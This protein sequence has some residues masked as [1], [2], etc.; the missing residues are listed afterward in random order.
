MIRESRFFLPPLF[1]GLLVLCLFVPR[2][3]GTE[4]Q[5]AEDA[6]RMLTLP[7]DVEKPAPP[8]SAKA[9][10]REPLLKGVVL[11]I[12]LREDGS[13]LAFASRSVGD[14]FNKTS[15]AKVYRG[16]DEI[17][18]LLRFAATLKGKKKISEEGVDL[19]VT[20][21]D[22]VL[23]T[24]KETPLKRFADLLLVACEQDIAIARFHIA[25]KGKKTG[26]NAEP[27]TWH[28]EDRI[29]RVLGIMP[30]EGFEIIS[31]TGFRSEAG[32]RRG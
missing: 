15:K 22:L 16:R 13:I 9:C 30:P 17:R 18:S 28:R 19:E 20:D 23:F 14:V 8:V 25:V 5:Q 24:S 6:F 31:A 29:I 27:R 26:E 1:A 21:V 3:R 2:G 10:F 32:L 12:L 11:E 4:P 7:K